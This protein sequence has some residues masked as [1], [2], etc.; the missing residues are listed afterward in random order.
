MAKLDIIIPHYKEDIA[1]MA[2]MMDILRIQ[3]NVKFTDFRV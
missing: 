1:L 3:R 2:P